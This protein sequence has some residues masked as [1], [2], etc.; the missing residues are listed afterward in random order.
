MGFLL[1]KAAVDEAPNYSDSMPFESQIYVIG[2]CAA[3]AAGW[4]HDRQDRIVVQRLQC[5]HQTYDWDVQSFSVWPLK[6]SSESPQSPHGGKC[7]KPSRVTLLVKLLP[8]LAQQF[9]NER[10]GGIQDLEMGFVYQFGKGAL[11]LIEKSRMRWPF[12][13]D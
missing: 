12:V 6:E 3:A 1:V 9:E 7:G 13:R 2:R 5:I 8:S 10:K 11:V 4:S